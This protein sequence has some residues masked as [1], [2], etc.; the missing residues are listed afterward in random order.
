MNLGLFTTAIFLSAFLLF[1]VQPLF[2]KM[3][4]PVLGGAPAVWSVALVFFQLMLLA[5]YLYAHLLIR[6]LPAKTGAFLHLAVMALGALF[7]PLELAK[8]FGNPPVSGEAAWLFGLFFVSIG[9][10]FFALSANGPLL[11]AWFSRTQH[12]RSGDPYFLYAASNAGSLLALLFYPVLLEP[13]LTLAEQ[14]RGWTAG[15]ACLGFLLLVLAFFLPRKTVHEERIVH[16]PISWQRRA[17]W[18]FFAFVPSALLIAVTAHIS[19]DVAAVPFLWV[20][21]LVLYLLTFIIAFSRNSLLPSARVSLIVPFAFT[22]LLLVL[23]SGFQFDNW[24]LMLF[25]HLL[26]FFALAMLNHARLA[27]DRPEPARLT[28]FYFFISLGGVIGGIFSGL[29]APHLFSNVTEYPLLAVLA[30]LALPGLREVYRRHGKRDA[31]LALCALGF[32][33]LAGLVLRQIVEDKILWLVV[34]IIIGTVLIADRRR[35][36]RVLLLSAG[37]LVFLPYLQ[38]TPANLITKRSFFGVHKVYDSNDN[39][40]RVL[41]HGTT[42]HGAEYKDPAREKE[43]LTYYAK[44]N[45]FGQVLQ[46]A[47]L[48]GAI[49]HI[50]VVGLGSGAMAC[51]VQPGET[52]TYFEIDPAVVNLARSEFNFLASCAP[53][54]RVVMGD[55]RLTLAD[56]PDGTYDILII[57][58]F[59][60]DAVPVHLLTQEA[61]RLYFSKLAPQGKLLL[62]ISNRN[63]EM[64]SM[65]ATSAAELGYH[66]LARMEALDEKNAEQLI[67]PSHVVVMAREEA[68]LAPLSK[69]PGWEKLGETST[70]AWRDDY[71]NI[72]EAMVRRFRQPR[73]PQAQ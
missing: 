20:I 65:L 69:M 28:E 34:A 13:W 8:N 47:R 5:G 68:T 44:M 23:V 12:E 19:T 22:P 31:V 41:Q 24:P 54:A 70:L 60:S 71:S 48:Q 32:T 30:L 37:A 15:Y 57:D 6:Y 26:G 50:G 17:K 64:E 59:T 33:V 63:L 27:E 16:D 73:Y 67:T 3:V 42:I 38:K 18:V 45:N 43:P 49:G 10:P 52:I 55:A 4:L 11:Q 2:A 21:P 53:E 9:L 66:A 46:A 39:Q 72:F 7:L 29:I 1:A 51:H 56:E 62:H 40:F 58:A 25:L 36:L 35:P 14:G 61:L